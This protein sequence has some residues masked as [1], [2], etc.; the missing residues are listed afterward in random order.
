MRG[1]MGLLLV[2]LLVAGC[3]TYVPHADEITDVRVDLVN[4]E[5]ED[6]SIGSIEWDVTVR[7][8]NPNSFDLKLEYLEATLDIG[9]TRL[10]TGGKKDITVPKYDDEEVTLT[11]H[12]STLG[13]ASSILGVIQSKDFNYTMGAEVT[14]KTQEGPLRRRLETSGAMGR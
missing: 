9:D 11:V 5:P 3:A 1:C 2:T 4:V 13:I 12:T 6:V 14:Y 7:V 10:G 8:A